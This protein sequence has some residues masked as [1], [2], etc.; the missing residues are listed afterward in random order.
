MRPP[1]LAQQRAV[2]LGGW[3]V[4]VRPRVAAVAAVLTAAL[5]FLAALSVARGDSVLPLGDVVTVLAGGGDAL[6]RLVVLELRLPR[7]VTGIVVGLALGLSGAITQSITRN[8]LASPDVL[9]VTA[10]ASAAAVAVIVLGG[11]S[12]AGTAAAVGLPA[13]ALAGGLITAA[14]VGLLSWNGGLDSQRLVLVGIAVAALGIATTNWLLTRA[15]LADATQAM[16]WLIGSLAGRGWVHVG[17]T[18]VALLVAVAGLLAV[19]RTLDALRFADD[20]TRALGVR[21]VAGRVLLIV[22]AVVLAATATA[23]AGPIAFVA[24]AAPQVALRLIRSPAPPLVLSALVGAVLLVGSD[25][26]VRTVLPVEL[27]V[28]VL[29]AVLGAPYLLTLLLATA[30]KATV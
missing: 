11:G 17:P 23:A 8:A 2:R 22:L 5:A 15:A 14:A 26:V 18:A 7:A 4:V 13:A 30:R 20:T 25:L 9:G 19:A 3:S 24:L 27:P 29:T 6:Q 21:P 12:V 1:V 10:G 28:G 16:A